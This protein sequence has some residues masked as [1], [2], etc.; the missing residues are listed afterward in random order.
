MVRRGGRLRRIAIRVF[1]IVLLAPLAILAVY[2]FVPPPATPLM[3]LRLVEGRGLDYRWVPLSRMAPAL[4]ES[5]VAAEDNLFCRHWGIDIRA[6]ET[7]IAAL[8]AGAETRGASTISMQVAKNLFL[9]PGRSYIRKGL[10]LWLTFYVELVL[11]KRRI[12]ELYLNIA[13]WGP[14]IYGAEAAAQHHFGVPAM[15]LTAGQT[16]VLAAVLPSP[17]TRSAAAP[18]GYVQD[19]ALLYRQRAGQ[20]DADLVGC[21]K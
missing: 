7:Q 21:W 18:S 4:P 20:L 13:E 10:E 15:R 12:I 5:V 6:L 3:L 14:G 11:P 2:R 8:R 19:R 9:W 1:G 16:A 17:L